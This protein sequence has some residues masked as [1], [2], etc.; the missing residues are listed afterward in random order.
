MITVENLTK[1]YSGVTAIDGLSFQV[2]KGEIVGFL[3]P[4]GAGK[5]TTMKILTGFMPATE[6]KVEVAGSDVFTDP[7]GVKRNIG[8]LP[9]NPPVYTD[10]TVR[11]YLEFA[12]KLKL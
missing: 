12:A 11:D 2:G 8:Y 10:M 4:N 6:G 7:I 5:S 1:R 9:E 3:G